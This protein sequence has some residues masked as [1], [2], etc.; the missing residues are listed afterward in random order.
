MRS[1]PQETRNDNH[2]VFYI[3]FINKQCQNASKHIIC[4]F[5]KF[6]KLSGKVAQPSQTFS[7][8][9]R[10]DPSFSPYAFL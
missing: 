8:V 4:T 3:N 9:G 10:G 1:A 6:T 2:L 7:S 5:R